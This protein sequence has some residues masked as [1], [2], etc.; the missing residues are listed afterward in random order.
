[1]TVESFMEDRSCPLCGERA[2]D[3]G[4]AQTVFLLDAEEARRLGARGARLGS[5]GPVL[6]P[7]GGSTGED[8]AIQR[9]I[10]AALKPLRDAA[11]R[12]RLVKLACTNSGHT[13]LLDADKVG[14]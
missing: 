13:E 11:V 4:G 7:H 5:Y 9:R 12:N 14:A 6:S 3:F 2:W 10:E 8:A 1:M